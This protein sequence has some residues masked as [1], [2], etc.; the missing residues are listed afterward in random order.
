MEA[1]LLERFTSANSVAKV[2]LLPAFAS[3]CNLIFLADSVPVGLNGAPMANVFRDEKA[4]Y[5][6]VLLIGIVGW[7]F[8]A[9][10]DTAKDLRIIEYRSVYGTDGQVNTVTFYVANRSMV[11]AI[12]SGRFSFRCPP[13]A[14]DNKATAPS[15]LTDIPSVSAKAQYLGSGNFGLP[16]PITTENEG[17]S[18][19]AL[20]PPKSE[21]GFKFGL[22]NKDVKLGFSYVLDPEDITGD[23]S[24]VQVRI[25]APQAG[26]GTTWLA[27]LDRLTLFVLANYFTVLMASMICLGGIL[28]IYFVASLFVSIFGNREGPA[29][30]K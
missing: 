3:T 4:P 9:A 13:P 8:N 29:D 28:V 2:V 6:I 15:C 19:E 16:E 14:A 17:A 12:N 7:M 18:V 1:F 30:D 24:S 21:V 10:L 25:L 23:K 27:K 5:V 26:Q 20:V 11:S 22:A